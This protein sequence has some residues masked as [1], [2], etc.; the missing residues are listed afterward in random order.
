MKVIPV[1]N[2]PLVLSTSMMVSIEL[3]LRYSNE[4]TLQKT[5]M[6]DIKLKIN[7]NNN[8]NN[9]NDSD[10]GVNTNKHIHYSLVIT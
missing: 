8:D 7:Y 6:P 1:L 2:G 10:K 9:N 3:P 4:N 5:V